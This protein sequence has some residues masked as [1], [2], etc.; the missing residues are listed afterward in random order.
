MNISGQSLTG[1]SLPYFITR[2]KAEEG[3]L[4]YLNVPDLDIEIWK[5]LIYH[6]NKWIS[7][8]LEAFLNYVME[9]EF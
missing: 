8:A 6:R 5:Q 7:Q 4:V 2:H 9:N 1:S 3:A